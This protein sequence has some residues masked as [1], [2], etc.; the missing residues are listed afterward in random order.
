M[1]ALHS[2]NT[3]NAA[4]IA[5][6]LKVVGCVLL[7]IAAIDYIVLL[8]PPDFSNPEWQFQLSSQITDRGVLPLLGVGLLTLSIWIEQFAGLSEK[9]SMR[10]VTL[11]ASVALALLFLTM[12]PLHFVSAGQASAAA[13]RQINE[14]TAQSE[15][16]LETRLQQERAQINAVLSDP[17][18]LTALDRELAKEDLPAE[19][20]ERLTTI[21]ENL[22]RFKADPTLLE[23]QEAETRNR[24]L[25]VIRT[26][27]LEQSKRVSL[28]FRKSRM[29]IPLS[30][31]MLAGA[32]AFIFWTGFTQAR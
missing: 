27:G 28:E 25:G 1:V 20:K 10:A 14:R 29:R 7:A 24:G 31:V 23:A 17:S 8:L 30:S 9:G 2:D 3:G 5:L 11:L 13:T 18:Q 16:E 32:F 19:S 15:A 22:T 21:K 26:E 6:A 12:A 4:P